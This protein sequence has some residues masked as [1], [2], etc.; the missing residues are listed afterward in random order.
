LWQKRLEEL[1]EKPIL[2]IRSGVQYTAIIIKQNF[3]ERGRSKPLE[4]KFAQT[5]RKTQRVDE[6]FIKKLEEEKT[7]KLQEE[8]EKRPTPD[9]QEFL[10]FMAVKKKINSLNQINSSLHF[11]VNNQLQEQHQDLQLQKKLD[12]QKLR[13]H[14]AR[15]QHSVKEKLLEEERKKVIALREMNQGRRTTIHQGQNILQDDWQKL[16]TE[17]QTFQEERK[18][19]APL[20]R[21]ILFRQQQIMLE[22]TRIFPLVKASNGELSI[23]EFNVPQWKEVFKKKEMK[24]NKDGTATALGCICH[25]LTMIEKILVFGF[26]YQMVEMGSQS[27]VMDAI[28]QTA[29]QVYPLY[30]TDNRRETF[31]KF[32][33]GVMLIANNLKQFYNDPVAQSHKELRVNIGMLMEKFWFA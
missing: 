20:Q 27:L 4:Q 17:N 24:E 23:C 12:L 1:N 13:T 11:V 6:L 19:L 7:K 10:K 14:I 3:I 33:A 25:L 2:Q 29:V 16:K 26:S 32:Q 9:K 18:V 22:L 15:E 5:N 21:K 31:D 28:S 30:L 8:Q